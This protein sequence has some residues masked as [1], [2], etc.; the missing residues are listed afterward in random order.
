MVRESR[1]ASLAQHNSAAAELI[2]QIT[3]AGRS[4][5]HVMLQITRADRSMQHVMLQ[6]TRAGRSMQHVMLRR[7]IDVAAC[8]R[9]CSM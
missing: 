9:R 1:T 4:M 8:D 6:I 5:Q 3:R 2:E 7:F